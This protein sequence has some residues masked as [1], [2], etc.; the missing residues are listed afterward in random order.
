[1]DGTFLKGLR[2]DGAKDETDGNLLELQIVTSEW[3]TCRGAF[4]GMPL[5]DFLLLYPDAIRRTQA[6]PGD[7][8][9]SYTNS[10]T[11]F[12]QLIFSFEEYILT[13]IIAAN[14]IDGYL[15]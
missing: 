10:S 15:Y 4:V 3:E 13:T 2:L 5:E 9:Y 7:F 14:G 8:S 11:G 1:M 6:G 12:N